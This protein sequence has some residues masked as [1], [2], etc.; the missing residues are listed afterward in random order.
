MS[1]FVFSSWSHQD[2]YAELLGRLLVERG[3][4]SKVEVINMAQGA[5]GFMTPMLCRAKLWSIVAQDPSIQPDVWITE[6]VENFDSS[7]EDYGAFLAGLM[8]GD[9]GETPAVIMVEVDDPLCWRPEW[10]TRRACGV[11]RQDS[12]LRSNDAALQSAARDLAIPLVMVNID[13][14]EP[15]DLISTNATITHPLLE[16]YSRQ[17][18]G[19]CGED[20]HFNEYGHRLLAEYIY[21]VFVMAKSAPPLLPVQHE[22]HH[23]WRRLSSMES[24]PLPPPPRGRAPLP[25]PTTTSSYDMVIDDKDVLLPRLSPESL[26]IYQRLQSQSSDHTVTC[27]LTLTQGHDIDLIPSHTDG[28]FLYVQPTGN[29][30]ELFYA[31]RTRSD[32][33]KTWMPGRDKATIDF[34]FMVPPGATSL[35]TIIYTAL[36]SVLTASLVVDEKE[37]EGGPWR[38]EF[39][40]GGA[41]TTAPMYRIKCGCELPVGLSDG[42][43]HTFRFTSTEGRVQIAG[44]VLW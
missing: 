2:S 39:R 4:V 33:K 29:K 9:K 24:P 13:G 23:W 42:A 8:W 31:D 18:H 26:A 21:R 36:G 37:E 12:G 28:Y 44:V 35:C 10:D 43:T 30:W 20:I 41:W 34:S 5:S 27:N 6:F 32:V 16:E 40:G 19:R 14:V 11:I 38:C 17:L 15:Y 7:L 1:C 3:V 22:R 25:P